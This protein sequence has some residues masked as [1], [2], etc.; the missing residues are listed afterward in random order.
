MFSPNDLPGETSGPI[1]LLILRRYKGLAN[2]AGQVL[3]PMIFKPESLIVIGFFL[4]SYHG[5]PI[6]VFVLR[7]GY[8]DIISV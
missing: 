2:D 3:F 4:Y 6:N 1:T 5:S 7:Q 8:L